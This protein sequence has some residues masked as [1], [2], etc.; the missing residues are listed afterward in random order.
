[1]SEV[2]TQITLYALQKL[3]TNKLSTHNINSRSKTPSYHRSNSTIAEDSQL[4]TFAP[5][6]QAFLTQTSRRYS[7]FG[8][9]LPLAFE[10]AAGNSFLNPKFDSQ[11]LEEQYQISILPQIRLRFRFA[12]LYILCMT[13]IWLFYFTFRAKDVAVPLN[14]TLGLLIIMSIAAIW[15]TFTSFYKKHMI[16]FSSMYSL[17]L[18]ASCLSWLY[19]AGTTLSVLGNFVICIICIISIYTVIPLKMYQCLLMAVA[20]S[21]AFEVLS[22]IMKDKTYYQPGPDGFHNIQIYQIITLRIM[23]HICV[24]I[25]SFHM[26]LMSSVRMRGTFI[27]VGQNLLVRRQL[28]LEKQLKEKM[29]TSMMPK[30]VADMLLKESKNDYEISIQK[31]RQSTSDF[32]LKSLFRPFHMHS[33]KNVSI[34]FADIVG[35]TKMSSKKTAEQLVEILNDL[36]ERFDSLCGIHGCEKISTLGDCYYC[37]SGCPHARD[38]HAICCVEMGLGMIE[39][40]KIFDAERHEGIKM[41][42]GIHTGNVLCGIV[43]TKRVKFDVW[44]N[45]V[46]FANKME[47]TGHPD[48]V[49][50]SEETKRFLDDSYNVREADEIDGHKTFFILN[51]RN[52]TPSQRSILSNNSLNLRLEFNSKKLKNLSTTDI[53]SITPASPNPTTNVTSIHHSKSLSPSPILNTRRR[54]ASISETVSKLLSSA[55]AAASRNVNSDQNK[56]FQEQRKALNPTIII[57]IS[58][59][60]ISNELMNHEQSNNGTIKDE[61]LKDETSTTMTTTTNNLSFRNANRNNDCDKINEKLVPYDGNRRGYQQLPSISVSSSSSPPFVV[62]NN[63]NQQH[64]NENKKEDECE[65]DD[66]SSVNITDLRSYISQSRCD[67]S[68]FSRSGSNRSSDRPQN[69]THH[70]SHSQHSSLSPWYQMQPNDFSYVSPSRKDSGIKTNSRR[71][72]IQHQHYY[73]NSLTTQNRVSGYYTSSQSSLCPTTE[74]QTEDILMKYLPPSSA[75]TAVGGVE[76]GVVGGTGNHHKQH[77]NGEETLK[78]CVQHLRKQSDLQLIKC[79]RDNARSQRSYLVKPPIRKFSLL[80]ESSMMEKTFRNKAHRYESDEETTT[81][82]YTLTT[83]KFNTFIDILV[84]TVIFGMVAFSLFLLSPSIYSRKYKVWVCCFVL[85]SSVIFS[86]LFLCTKQI[87]RRIRNRHHTNTSSNFNSIFGWTSKFY[88]W[89]LFGCL[90]ISLPVASILV[91]F[92]LTDIEKFPSIQFYYG[93]LLFVCLIHFCNFIQLNCWTKTILAMLSAIIFIIIAYDH[94]GSRMSA[95]NLSQQIN[96]SIN[97]E[98]FT[99]SEDKFWYKHFEF[100]L[101]LDIFLVLILVFLLNREFEIGYRLS[102]YGNEVANQDKIKVQNM[103]NQ[104]DLLLHNIIPKHVAEELK[105]TAKYSKNHQDVGIIFASIVNFNEMYDESYLGG[106]EYLR[107]LNELIGDFDELLLRQEFKCIEKIKTIGSTYMCASGLDSTYRSDS[108]E[109]LYALLDFAVAMQNALDNFNRDLLEFNLVLRIGFNYGEVT[110]GVIGTTKLHYDIWGDAVNVASRMDSTGIPGRIQLRK[111]CVPIFEELY[112]FE[113]RGKV[114]VKGKDM[115]DI[116]GSNLKTKKNRKCQVCHHTSFLRCIECDIIY[117]SLTCLMKDNETHKH[118]RTSSQAQVRSD[119]AN[120]KSVQ[121][122]NDSI[123]KVKFEDSLW[124]KETVV[125]TPMDIRNKKRELQPNTSLNT[126]KDETKET[127]PKINNQIDRIGQLDRK[128]AMKFPWSEEFKDE[129]G[130]VMIFITEKVK[131]ID[132]SFIYWVVPEDIENL[133]ETNRKAFNKTYDSSSSMYIEPAD[134]NKF[135]EYFVM[136]KIDGN[137]LRC[138]ISYIY[139]EEKYTILEDIDSGKKHITTFLNQTQFK[140]PLEKELAIYA[141]AS[142]IKLENLSSDDDINVGDFVKIRKTCEND[143]DCQVFWRSS[144]DFWQKSW[145]GFLDFAGDDEFNLFIWWTTGYTFLLYWS[146][147]AIYTLMDLTNRPKFLRKYKIQPNTNEP[148]DSKQLIKVIMSVVFNQIFI[149]IPFAILSFYLMK[150]RGIP[151]MRKLPT[152]HGILFD[153]IV[154]IFVE[155][156]GFYYSHRLMHSK[157][158]YKHIHK[159]HHLWQSP[160]AV[161]AIYAHPI[162]H[163]FSNMLPPFLGVLI[164]GSHITTAWLWFS[165]ALL[166]TL[167]AHSGYHFPFFPSPE[168]HDFHHLKFNTNY[169]MLGFLD[170]IHGT[171]VLFRN[172]PQGRRHIMML[173]F[174]PAH[175]QFPSKTIYNKES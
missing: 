69:L 122:R 145:D 50:I 92:T 89:N 47:S 163:I 144:G 105:N 86:V 155:E 71:S 113:S 90:L 153:I 3:L 59:V 78:A 64:L 93:L 75:S 123:E 94:H 125:K 159:Q 39:A 67:V 6:I 36:F 115:M 12:L 19:N 142:P 15:V 160:V 22:Y 132:G 74:Y 112:E 48:R 150:L 46:T 76:G 91:N 120:N 106:K 146:F 158:I 28:E 124:K 88:P 100:E 45:D 68:P 130:F 167:N 97:D 135:K 148:V 165:M 17:L 131:N 38:D 23:L 166:S 61:S 111:E 133:Y 126:I 56:N 114:Y 96:S 16:L 65:G 171:D 151:E 174:T 83:P 55:A 53:P 84:L 128:F 102:F 118:Q 127:K 136:A 107:V 1:M 21:I 101:F 147:G 40:M 44:S 77:L 10:R 54:L 52:I 7:C 119:R 11:V 81:P 14:V 30:V 73:K 110:A 32:N 20:Y 37:V 26:M 8:V 49:H 140:V 169:G 173:S 31:P 25:I 43:G 98:S 170:R 99:I 172:S 104:A 72:S 154:C 2:N 51:R 143:S 5:Y 108:Y 58:E 149:G 9:M 134:L 29:I 95:N 24:H 156:F 63:A 41:R 109:H 70:R 80:F 103:K 138:T 116:D 79:V 168:A 4:T 13:I 141:F 57:G 121:D 66:S 129:K 85:S 18:I 164:C 34:L 60:S 117:C 82:T 42:V 162:E 139:E 137:W 161:T 175:E 62:D 27:K 152:F 157:R 33:M 87:C 35:F